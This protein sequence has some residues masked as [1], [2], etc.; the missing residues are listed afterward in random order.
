MAMLQEVVLWTGSL[1]ICSHALPYLIPSFYATLVQVH[2][3]IQS[4]TVFASESIH[5]AHQHQLDAI[6]RTIGQLVA[7]ACQF[8]IVLWALWNRLMAGDLQPLHNFVLGF[9]LHD[10]IH[11]LVKPYGKTLRIFL[12]HHGVAIGLVLYLKYCPPSYYSFANEAYL[13]LELSAFSINAT[14]VFRRF[15]ITSKYN[16]ALSAL[17]LYLYCITRLILYPLMIATLLLSVVLSP[18]P[19]SLLELAPL[20]VLVGL[21][22][23]SANWFVAMVAKHKQL[24]WKTIL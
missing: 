24:V 13:L 5:D 12:V 10:T 8:L 15:F 23:V 17:N 1:L 4:N 18:Q 19:L 21:I 2:R 20:P 9:Y 16:I 3:S 11:L 7:G 6:D 14:H 22:G